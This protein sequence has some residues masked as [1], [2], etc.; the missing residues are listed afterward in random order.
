MDR[1]FRPAQSKYVNLKSHRICWHFGKTGHI[2]RNCDALIQVRQKKIQFAHTTQYQKDNPEK[3][4]RQ[5]RPKYYNS[6]VRA[7]VSYRY[8]RYFQSKTPRKKIQLTPDQD[9]AS[10]SKF[11][12]NHTVPTFLKPD[13]FKQ[14]WVRTKTNSLFCRKDHQ[15]EYG[16][17]TAYAPRI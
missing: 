10:K 13:K 4:H 17:L 3:D 7:Q 2:R 8:P 1:P 15:V 14:V 11:V 6:R 9:T 5:H 16:I 12:T